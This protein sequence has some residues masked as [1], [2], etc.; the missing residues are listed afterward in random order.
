MGNCPEPPVKI[1]DGVL[2]YFHCCQWVKIGNVG[3]LDTGE[4]PP[5]DMWVTPSNPNPTYSACG[6]A[7]AIVNAIYAVA[8]A[9]WEENDNPY[10]WQW[11]GHV[12]DALPGYDL[13]DKYSIEAVIEGGILR[14]PPWSLSEEEVFDAVSKQQVLCHLVRSFSDTIGDLTDADFDAIN[15]AFNQSLGFEVAIFGA[16]ANA[17]GKA[18]LTTIAKLSAL[19]TD[20]DCDCPELP[21]G[22]PVSYDWLHVYDFSVSLYDWEDFEGQWVEG[23]GIYLADVSQYDNIGLLSKD[24]AANTTIK[25]IAVQ[26]TQW[27]SSP[28]D[29]GVQPFWLGVDGATEWFDAAYIGVQW[30]QQVLNQ[31]VS[32]G[33][34][35]GVMKYQYTN[36][37][38][39]GSSCFKTLILA[40]TGNDPFPGDP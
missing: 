2:W 26:M 31:A 27:P 21:P 3:A 4:P 9:A 28:W 33:H 13:K 24:A 29:G 8:Q 23:Q 38:V 35:V 7:N 39:A 10:F 12:N 36:S 19:D 1:V 17:I 37:E 25:Y 30:L 15:N 20:A 22:V 14:A 11:P 6:M 32:N 34:T 16:A 18:Q 40:G 5:D